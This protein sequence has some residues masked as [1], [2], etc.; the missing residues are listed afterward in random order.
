LTKIAQEVARSKQKPHTAAEIGLRV[1]KALGHYKVGKHFDCQ[2]G[3]GHF[4][5]SRA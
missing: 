5:W 2:I 1:G 4:S 3:E